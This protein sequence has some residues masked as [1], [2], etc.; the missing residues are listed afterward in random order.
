MTA[1]C[2]G[3]VEF[4]ALS[5]LMVVVG[6]PFLLVTSAPAF[7]GRGRLSGIF[8]PSPIHSSNVWTQ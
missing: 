6:V 1:H 4:A 3:S 8:L 5:G 2:N 7:P